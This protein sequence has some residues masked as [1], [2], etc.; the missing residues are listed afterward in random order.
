FADRV[1]ELVCSFGSTHDGKLPAVAADVC[2]PDGFQDLTRC[3]TA[4]GCAGERADLQPVSRPHSPHIGQ[5]GY[6]TCARDSDHH[7][8]C[9]LKRARVAVTDARGEDL[10]R[11]PLP[12]CAVDRVLAVRREAHSFDIAALESKLLKANWAAPAACTSKISRDRQGQECKDREGCLQP[13]P[14]RSRK[15]GLCGS[16]ARGPAERLQRKAQ[17]LGRLK[18]LL[19]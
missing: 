10:V 8:G 13:P 3:T 9:Q 12:L 14:A 5:Y 17:V 2:V 1:F 4:Q 15:R 7:R 16:G 18:T 19:A 11:T 6:V